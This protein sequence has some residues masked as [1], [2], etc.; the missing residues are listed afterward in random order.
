MGL[1]INFND[2]KKEDG[3]Q[4]LSTLLDLVSN[5][6]EKVNRTILLKMQS[7]VPLI[8]QLAGH[9]IA[10][11]G[12][13]LRPMLTLAASHLCGY[14]GERHVQLATCVEFIHSATLLHDDVVDES[15]LRRGLASANAVWGNQA[16]V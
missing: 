10:S 5:D 7:S 2:E 16:S 9:L 3:K 12:K 1:V 8:P 6:L 13:R 11:G 15:S 14:E 4:A